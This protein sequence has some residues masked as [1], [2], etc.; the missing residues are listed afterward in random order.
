[1]ITLYGFNGDYET[2]HHVKTHHS[3]YIAHFIPTYRTSTA[4]F[5]RFIRDKLI[6][7]LQ[8]RR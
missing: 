7:M 6:S 4:A 8:R 1:M 2:W 5:A 3:L